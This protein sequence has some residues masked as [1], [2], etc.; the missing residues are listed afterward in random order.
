MGVVEFKMGEKNKGDAIYEEVMNEDF[1]KLMRQKRLGS[2]F[3]L[4][5]QISKLTTHRHSRLNCLKI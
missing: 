4:S 5:K 2:C 1:T 3:Q